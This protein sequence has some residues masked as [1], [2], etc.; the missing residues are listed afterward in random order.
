MT[1]QELAKVMQVCTC[2]KLDNHLE[3][4]FFSANFIQ[5]FL[6]A[7]ELSKYLLWS[8]IMEEVS[9]SLP[10]TMIILCNKTIFYTRIKKPNLKSSF[11]K[12][13][14][15]ALDTVLWLLSPNW[16]L[17]EILITIWTWC[18][19]NQRHLYLCM[20][21]WVF[22]RI[23]VAIIGELSWQQSGQG[24]SIMWLWV[25][26]RILMAVLKINNNWNRRHL[27]YLCAYEGVS[28]EL[29]HNLDSLTTIKGAEL[30]LCHWMLQG[31]VTGLS[32]VLHVG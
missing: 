17:Q 21:L 1:S 8:Q 6:E 27:I 10:L 32:C 14:V 24:A 5:L 26:Q 11:L 4:S 22:Q 20:C 31:L 9:Y 13:I 28:K 19:K 18:D 16:V 3:W 12:S 29:D 23:L 15:K 7:T 30:L 2:C 25:L